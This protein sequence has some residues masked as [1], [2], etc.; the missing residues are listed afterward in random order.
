MASLVET[1][2]AASGVIADQGASTVAPETGSIAASGAAGSFRPQLGRPII[3]TLTGTWAGT[4]TLTRSVDGGTTKLPVT[5]AG[6]PWAVFTANC[7]EPVWEESEAGATFHLDFARVSGTVDF[8][9][10]Q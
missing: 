8:R 2:A 9:F 5:L 10:A 4:V 3:L 1:T 7:N 6:A